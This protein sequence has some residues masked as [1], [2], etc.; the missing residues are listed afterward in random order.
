M[1]HGMYKTIYDRISELEHAEHFFLFLSV[2][3]VH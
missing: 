3:Y 1:I 2:T